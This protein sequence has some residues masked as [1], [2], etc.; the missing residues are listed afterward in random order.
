MSVSGVLGGT[1]KVGDGRNRGGRI[2]IDVTEMKNRKSQFW[3]AIFRPTRVLLADPDD[4]VVLTEIP[5][6]SSTSLG[7][8]PTSLAGNELEKVAKSPKRN[9]N[10]HV[11]A[12]EA[13]A[14]IMDTGPH[15]E[16]EWE[17]ESK[18]SRPELG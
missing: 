14:A 8:Y 2:V 4:I 11:P 18:E 16:E 12:E 10:I 5:P 6:D 1:E 13:I 17:D 7:S 9:A 3:T 15:P